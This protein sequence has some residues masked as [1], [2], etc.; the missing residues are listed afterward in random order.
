MNNDEIAQFWERLTA[1]N[2]GFLGTKSGAAR[3]VPMSHA[4]RDGDATIWFI[5][6]RDTDLAEAVEHS[7]SDASYVVAESGKGLYA[8]I[9]GQLAQN[10][11]PALRDEL[12]SP[13]AD[14]WFQGGKD[15][16]QVCILGLRPERAEIWLTTT[17]GLSF[18]YNIVRAQVTGKQPDM[19]SH[20]EASGDALAQSRVAP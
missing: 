6:A 19:G 4:L 2:A 7:G 10:N 16:P 8:V 13:V 11:D 18:A 15:D 17:S 1:I 14:S 5:T 9:H 3:M 12:W 20:G